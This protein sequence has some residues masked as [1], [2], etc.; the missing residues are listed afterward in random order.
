MPAELAKAA[1]SGRK[2]NH[3]VSSHS[4]RSSS[5]RSKTPEPAPR[6]YIKPATTQP[7]YEV[8]PEEDDDGHILP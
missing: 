3:S 2:K 1:A 7:V 8:P 6:G 5:H 4:S